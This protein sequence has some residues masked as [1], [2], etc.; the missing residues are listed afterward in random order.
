MIFYSHVNEDN[1]V[2]R[3]LLHSGDFRGLACVAG[4]GERLIA[5]LDQKHLEQ[6]FAVDPNAD[7]LYL[8]EMKLAAIEHLE[9][10]AYLQFVG[11]WDAPGRQRIEW[12]EGL[13]P[14]LSVRCARFWEGRRTF[15]ETGICYA[16]HFE[17]F[18][19]RIRPLVNAVLGKK[20]QEGFQRDFCTIKGFPAF[21][22]E[23]VKLLFSQ[24][25]AYRLMGNR[26]PAFTGSGSR[27]SIITNG[28]QT[29]LDENKLCESFMAHLI[30]KGNLEE[31]P[32][33]ALPP[34]LQPEVLL[35]VQ[36]VL[37]RKALNI[38]FQE[39]DF[40]T[41]LHSGVNEEQPALFCSF[42]DVMSFEVPQYLISCL[43]ALKSRAAAVTFVAR[44]FIRN[45]L[46]PPVLSRIGDMGY[47]WEELPGAD[48]SAMYRVFKFEL[49]HG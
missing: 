33:A 19:G 20:F 23:L 39:T 37:R 10:E 26:D 13:K 1:E 21:R 3:A 48:R 2:E 38:T 8:L 25:W 44:T 14:A 47:S 17:R 5:L 30:F 46:T 43:Q 15:I 22:W 16:G 28:L 7:A 36:Q 32:P 4:S 24:T 31:M 18:L 9:I 42:S 35:R 34:S 12:F 6:V 29:L 45:E 27:A 40:L 41:F 49:S 11:F